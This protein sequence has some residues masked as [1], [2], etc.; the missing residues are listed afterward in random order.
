MREEERENGGQR[1]HTPVNGDSQSGEGTIH[2]KKT[3]PKRHTREH[4]LL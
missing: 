3:L 1:A 2:S 4:A